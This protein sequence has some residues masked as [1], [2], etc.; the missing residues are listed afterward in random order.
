MSSALVDRIRLGWVVLAEAGDPSGDG[1]RTQPLERIGAHEVLLG[2]DGGGVPCLLIAVDRPGPEEDVGVVTVRNRELETSAGV[3][4]FVVVACGDPSLRDVFDHFLVGL[5]AALE[6]NQALNPGAAAIEVLAHWQALFRSGSGQMSRSDLAALLAELLVLEEVVKHDPQCSLDVWVGPFQARHDLRRG[7]HAIEV[8]STLSHTRRR[9]RVNGV[10]QLEAPPGGSL[11]LAWY[12]FESV[13]AGSL[14]VFAVVDRLIGT[15]VSAV[16]LFRLLEA[17]GCPPSK[18]DAY[19]PIRFEL[20]EHRFFAV[21]DTF[22]RIVAASFTGG[23]APVGV[24]ELTY[25]ATLPDDVAGLDERAV[26]G[27]LRVLAGAS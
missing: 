9:I 23:A 12:R 18:R 16:D 26:A 5:L 15:G 7:D 10:D 19:D 25:E 22:P 6:D 27:V 1:L 13:P 21:D 11:T 3:G 2:R 4:D 14:S 24:D 20:R 8:K 17:A